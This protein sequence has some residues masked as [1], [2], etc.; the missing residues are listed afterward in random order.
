MY[1]SLKLGMNKIPSEFASPW[2]FLYF[3][4]CRA[5]FD[6]LISF[7][8]RSRATNSTRKNKNK[9][10]KNNEAQRTLIAQSNVFLDPVHH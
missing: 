9:Q 5:L 8:L 1:I 7:F 4:Y 10:T 2:Y 6:T 3:L